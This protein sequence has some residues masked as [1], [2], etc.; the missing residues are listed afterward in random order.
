MDGDLGEAK[1]VLCAIK[2][3]QALPTPLLKLLANHDGVLSN[4]FVG[5]TLE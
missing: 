1:P 4:W 3:F 5:L 2:S